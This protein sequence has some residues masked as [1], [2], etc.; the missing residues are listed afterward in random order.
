VVQ[1]EQRAPNG[2]PIDRDPYFSLMADADG[3]GFVHCSDGVLVVP[4][5]ADGQV[6]L[7]VERSPAFDREV[8]GLVSGSVVAGES[9]EET[10]NR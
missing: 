1:Y 9:L 2:H 7:A 6:L 10:A 8:L 4:V 3:V 5:T